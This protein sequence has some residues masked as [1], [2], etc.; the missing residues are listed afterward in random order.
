MKSVAA[1]TCAGADLQHQLLPAQTKHYRKSRQVE[2]YYILSMQ[3]IAF[4]RLQISLAV[5][6]FVLLLSS[7]ASDKSLSD[8]SYYQTRVVK[9]RTSRGLAMPALRNRQI[10]YADRST[11]HPQ[12]TNLAKTKSVTPVCTSGITSLQPQ[13]A[14]DIAATGN[15]LYVNPARERLKQKISN[16]YRTEKDIKSFRRQY[17]EIRRQEA[18]RISRSLKTDEPQKDSPKRKVNGGL[19]SASLVFAL[20]GLF[21][22]GIICGVLAIVC[23]LIGMNK[24]MQGVAIAGIILG[25]VD[26]LGVLIVLGAL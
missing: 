5:I 10:K 15:N 24:G 16:L 19:S 18:E 14:A 4:T 23:G 11:A 17:K 7:C 20:M 1:A 26:I 25:V 6:T 2:L 22:A 3:K 13:P 9:P 21:V 8:G 12:D